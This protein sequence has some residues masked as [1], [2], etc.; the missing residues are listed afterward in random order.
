M[1]KFCR[2]S[3]EAISCVFPVVCGLVKHLE[4][5]SADC[6]PVIANFI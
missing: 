2:F 4:Q 3:F 1:F 5:L 6:L